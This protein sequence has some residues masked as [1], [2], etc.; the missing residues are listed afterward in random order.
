MDGGQP[1]GHASPQSSPA[2]GAVGMRR[3]GGSS[4]AL[5]SMAGG[6][7][8]EVPEQGGS[9]SRHQ[10]DDLQGVS[11]QPRGSEAAPTQ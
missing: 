5:A 3:Q 11:L 7:M 9:P 10:R 2:L 6:G 4:L 8:G 1:A